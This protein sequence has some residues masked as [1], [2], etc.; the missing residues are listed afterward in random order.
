MSRQ[1]ADTY[2]FTDIDGSRPDCW[3][4]VDKYGIDYEGSEGID[5]FR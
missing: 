2:D 5:D 1:L 3:G 4:F